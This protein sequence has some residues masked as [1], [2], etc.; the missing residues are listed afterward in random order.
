[1]KDKAISIA[2]RWRNFHGWFHDN[3]TCKSTCSTRQSFY[4]SCCWQS[5]RKINRNNQPNDSTL[6]NWNSQFSIEYSHWDSESYTLW[7][8]PYRVNTTLVYMIIIYSYIHLNP[9]T[10]VWKLS[11]HIQPPKVET[12]LADLKFFPPFHGGVE[13]YG[14]THL[15]RSFF[16][17]FRCKVG[18]HCGMI[19]KSYFMAGP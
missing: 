2:E 3:I 1:M 10:R 5:N 19:W 4:Q 9:P 7:Y 8:R 18:L 13:W 17:S 15:P 11:P 6:P 12:D 16:G 14:K